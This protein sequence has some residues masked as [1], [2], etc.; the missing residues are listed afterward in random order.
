M[1]ETSFL[2]SIPLFLSLQHSLLWHLVRKNPL[3]SPYT[4]FNVLGYTYTFY[5]YINFRIN[6]SQFIDDPVGIMVLIAFY[7][8]FIN[9]NRTDIFIILNFYIQDHGI[10]TVFRSLKHF[11]EVNIAFYLNLSCLLLD[12]FIPI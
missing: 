4:I 9:W 5:L 6:L 11:S 10:S 7:Y 12:L 1:K 8:E 3:S 2:V